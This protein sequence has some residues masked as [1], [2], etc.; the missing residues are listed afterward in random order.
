MTVSEI[1]FQE[2]TAAPPIPS[3]R[4]WRPWLYLLLAASIVF[5]VVRVSDYFLNDHVLNS[6]P[7]GGEGAHVVAGHTMYFG[8]AAFSGVGLP[9]SGQTVDLRSAVPRIVNDTTDASVTVMTCVSSNA[10]SSLTMGGVAADP[11]PFC[12]SIHN[13]RPGALALGYR[14]AGLVLRVTPLHSGVIH[15]AG[16]DV[17]YHDGLRRGHQQIGPDMTITARR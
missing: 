15:I 4:R 6:F 14:A 17:S 5:G 3:S 1:A 12:T 16:V 9:D 10:S 8:L 2:P 13:F 11:T 7:A